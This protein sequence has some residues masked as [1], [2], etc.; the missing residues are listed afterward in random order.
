MF[1][2]LSWIGLNFVTILGI[3][4]AAIKALKEILTGVVN[5]ISLFMT[6]EQ[7]ELAVATLRSLVNKADE[8]IEII[9]NKLL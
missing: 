7:A 6:K 8:F 1:K 2:I 4:Q 5:L 9:K 3:A